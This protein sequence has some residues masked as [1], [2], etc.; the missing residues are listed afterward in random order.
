MPRKKFSL[1]EIFDKEGKKVG[2]SEGR[3]VG[4]DKRSFSIDKNI[5]DDIQ[6]LAWFEERSVSEMVEEALKEYLA[7]NRKSLKRAKEFRR[8]KE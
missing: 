5:I 2:T 8:S 7:N 1:S 3:K 6:A 4:K